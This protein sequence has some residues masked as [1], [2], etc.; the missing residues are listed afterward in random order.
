VASQYVP[1]E[2]QNEVLRFL[3][4]KKNNKDNFSEKQLTSS[5]LSV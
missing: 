3:Y 4:N 5:N 1:E 2:L